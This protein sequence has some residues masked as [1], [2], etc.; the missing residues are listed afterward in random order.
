MHIPDHFLSLPVAA[1][2]GA[3]AATTL[4]FSFWRTPRSLPAARVPLLGLSAAFIFAAQLI[5]FPIATGVSGHLLGGTLAGILLG[6]SAAMVALSAVLLLQCLMFAD[7]GVSALGANI[8]NLA[9]LAPLAGYAT[10]RLFSSLLPG[11]AGSLASAAVAAW[12]S[13]MVAAAACAGQI[14]LSGRAPAAAAF[15]AMLGVHALV[16]IGEAAITALVLSAMW[17]AR[18]EL[19]SEAGPVLTSKTSVVFYG[20]A[21]AVALAVFVS[22]FACPWPD[23][24]EHVAAE[25]LGLVMDAE[26]P[27]LSAY[28]ADYRFPGLSNEY[29][30]T[31][32]AGAAGVL[33]LFVVARVLARAFART[34][35][36]ATEGKSES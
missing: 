10:W 27:V 34:A 20:S 8:L 19:A 13:T 36:P 9:I 12:L 26:R 33:A 11:R 22:P 4:G 7:G 35:E 29:V 23:G 6:P 17:M 14:V 1:A 24:L 25:R 2:S 15:P 32:F 3:I 5:N 21:C 30:S 18:P 28:L 16:G 31:A